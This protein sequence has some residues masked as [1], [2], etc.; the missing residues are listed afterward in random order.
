MIRHGFLPDSVIES[1]ITPVVKNKNGDITSASNYRPI[2]IASTMSKIIENLILQSIEPLIK[3]T[4]NQFGFKKKHST[5]LCNLI[6]KETIRN[7]NRLGSNIYACFIDAS[8]AFDRVNHRKLFITL[9]QR[10]IPKVLLRF[11]IYWYGNQRMR[12]RWG[13]EFSDWFDVK[14]GVRQ[15]GI[16]SPLLFNLYVDVIS[17]ELNKTHIGCTIGKIIVNHLYYADDLILFCPSHKGLQQL[18]NICNEIGL[19]LDIKFNE[20][21]TECIVFKTVKEEKITYNTFSLNGVSLAFCK[22]YKYLGHIVD[23]N[24]N[25]DMDITRQMRS[26]YARGNK[27]INSFRHCTVDVKVVLFKTYISNFYC[28]HLWCNYGKSTFQKFKV[29]YNNIFR[30]FFNIRYLCSISK[31]MCDKTI[32]VVNCV[33]RNYI[34]SI[35][36]RIYVSENEKI[37]CIT[38]SD[39]MEYSKL[40]KLCHKYVY[41][42]PCRNTE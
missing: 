7:Y 41:V 34:N 22:K 29:A 25:D 2:T 42:I 30:N 32:N 21:K 28:A 18:L 14:N 12:A 4:S 13:N 19:K 9:E 3:T 26:I 36:K 37:K 10:K 31:E 20:T 39:L 16:L 1:T 23:E 17:K 38:D 15:G 6:L 27:L 24:L 35:M 5:D 11:L 8:K 40:I 33:I